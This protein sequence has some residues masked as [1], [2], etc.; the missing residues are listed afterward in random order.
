[1]EKVKTILARKQ[2]YFNTVASD[3]VISEALH[4]MNCENSDYLIVM[5]NDQF[6][7][8]ITEHDIASK[9]MNKKLPLNQIKVREM[10]NH[11]LPIIDSEETLERCLKMM[12]LFKTHYLPVFEN[13]RFYGVISSDDILFEAVKNRERIFD[14]EEDTRIFIF[15]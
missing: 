9:A 12:Q 2:P 8:L 7:G 3:T 10:M 13:F 6:L 1:M 14:Q 4:K 11:G 5:N 15:N